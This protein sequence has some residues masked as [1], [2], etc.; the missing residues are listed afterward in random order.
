MDKLND[1]L[2]EHIAGGWNVD[3]LTPE[4]LEEF[5]KWGAIIVDM[6]IA[7]TR[8]GVPY[9]KD[10][11]LAAHNKLNELDKVFRAKYG[12]ETTGILQDPIRKQIK[13]LRQCL[14]Q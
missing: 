3:D 12:C 7:K 8:D 11:Y 9:N 10:E 2:L 4:E 13:S 5:E 1:E 14:Y 6:Q